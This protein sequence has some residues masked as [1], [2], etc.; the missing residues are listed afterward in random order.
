MKAIELMKTVNM[1]NAYETGVSV[2]IDGE[3]LPACGVCMGSG[4]IRLD[5]WPVHFSHK[6]HRADQ[7]SLAGLINKAIDFDCTHLDIGADMLAEKQD[8]WV[9]QYRRFLTTSLYYGDEE[10]IFQV[11]EMPTA[12]LDDFKRNLKNLISGDR[13]E[14]LDRA[15]SLSQRIHGHL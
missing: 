14:L 13:Q 3:K 6:K 15:Q 1:R 9:Y 4:L 2:F 11:E 5:I 8:E 12:S 10:I 7:L